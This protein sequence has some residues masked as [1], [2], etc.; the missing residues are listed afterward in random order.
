[1]HVWG[2]FLY[3]TNNVFWRNTLV[4]CSL[5]FQKKTKTTKIFIISFPEIDCDLHKTGIHYHIPN[6]KQNLTTSYVLNENSLVNEWINLNPNISINQYHFLV[7]ILLSFVS[8]YYLQ[9]S[10]VR[11]NHHKCLLSPQSFFHSFNSYWV[12]ALDQALPS[13]P[14]RVKESLPQP[15]PLPISKMEMQNWDQNK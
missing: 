1:M 12:F 6:C 13:E 7:Q 5:Y 15:Y 9:S 3:L 8:H 2:S 11:N 4:D 10:N 14:G